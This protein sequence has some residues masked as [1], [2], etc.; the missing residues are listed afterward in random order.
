MAEGRERRVLF[1][2]T[3]IST[4]TQTIFR[5]SSSS[6]LSRSSPI[7]P[8]RSFLLPAPPSRCER[9]SFVPDPIEGISLLLRWSLFWSRCHCERINLLRPNYQRVTCSRSL[10]QRFLLAWCGSALIPPFHKRAAQNAYAF[11]ILRKAFVRA[12]DD[13]VKQEVIGNRI[14]VAATTIVKHGI[15]KHVS[16]REAEVYYA[17]ILPRI[18]QRLAIGKQNR[19]EVKVKYRSPS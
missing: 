6:C 12:H 19:Y 14:A 3:C 9:L 15:V 18:Y 5:P 4:C 2:H 17:M 7:V 10:P 11:R 1:T 13:F 8:S 16:K